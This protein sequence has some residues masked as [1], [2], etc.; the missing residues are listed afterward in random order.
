[1]KR[2]TLDQ[3]ARVIED[4]KRGNGVVGRDYVPTNNG[5]RRSASK[6]ALLR[7]LAKEVADRGRTSAFPAKF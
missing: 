3:Q 1:M 2:I 7:N 6:R 5:T 4:W